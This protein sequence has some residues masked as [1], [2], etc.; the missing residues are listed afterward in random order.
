MN[1]PAYFEKTRQRSAERWIQ[2]EADKELA[3]PWHQLFRQV[4]SPRHVLSELLQNADDAGAKKASVSFDGAT[5]VFEHDGD[6]FNEEQF[7]SLCRFGFSNKRSLHTIGFRGIGF[8]STF[9]LGDRVEVL[10]PSL[11]VYFQKKR[12]TEP[13]W[14]EGAQPRD[15]TVVRVEVTDKNRAHQ[16]RANLTEW[17]ESPSSLLFFRCLKELTIDGATVR[18]RVTKSGPVPK[19]R[20]LTLTGEETQRLLLLQSAA[21]ALPPEAVEELRAERDVE[22]LHLP[23]CEVEVVLGLDQPQR[24]YVVLPTGAE[25]PLPFSI[26]APFIQDPARM[27]IKEPSTSPTNRWLLERAGRLVG[28]TML[29]WLNNRSLTLDERAVAYEFLSDTA[30]FD[31]TK[32][33]GE[34]AEAIF[35]SFNAVIAEHPIVLTTAGKVVGS[36]EAVA[37]PAKLHEVWEP[38]PL[39]EI[40]G[41]EGHRHVAANEISATSLRAMH[42]RE[43]INAL[44][45]STVI[46]RL[47]KAPG[48]V[49]PRSWANLQTL[50]EFVSSQCPYEWQN[51]TLRDLNIVPT[52]GDRVLHAAK[53]VIRLSSKREQLSDDDWNFL[54]A[55]SSVVLPDWI[56]WLSKLAPKRLEG[57]APGKQPDAVRLLQRLGLH[58][59][60]PVDRLV[61]NASLRLID[62]G[63]P[64]V[65]DCVRM[66]QIIAA[67]SAHVPDGFKFVTRD[68]HLRPVKYGIVDDNRGVV[69]AL[70]P[71]SWG[72]THL[73]H[74]DYTEQFVSCKQQQWTEWASSSSSGL[75][76]FV[77]VQEIK[78]RLWSRSA[79]ERVAMERGGQKPTRYR[80][81]R[82]SFVL[83]DHGFEKALM[84]NWGEE[85]KTDPGLW[86]R[87]MEAVLRAPPHAWKD[88]TSAVIHQ[89]GNRY[90]E[91]L[92]C[93]AVCAAWI[94]RFRSLACIPDNFGKLHV[95]AEL[96]ILTPDTAP[97]IGIEGFV[98]PELDTPANR[99]LLRLLGVRENAADAGK[100][101]NRI[102]ALAQARDPSRIVTEI[103][104]LYEALDR[105][106]AR[107]APEPLREV[108]A[109]FAAEAIILADN[110]EWLS[111]G[112]ISIF[113]DT[114]V[115]AP[116]IHSSV[117]RLA[118]WPRLDMPERPAV[119]KTVEW[120]RSLTAGRK[121]DPAELKRV[122]FALQR[123]PVRIWHACGHW[124]TLDNTWAEVGSLTLRLT[125]Q[126]LTKWSD[127]SPAIK[128]ATANFQMLSEETTRI[129]PFSNLRSLADSVEFRVT[130]R[131]G[132]GSESVPAWLEELSSGFCRLRIGSE[133][134]TQRIRTVGQRLRGSQWTR[135]SRIEVTPYVDG[136]PA[137]EPTTPK[138]FWSGAQIYAANVAIARL[139]KDLAD[140]ISRPFAHHG[141]ASAIGACLDRD[142]DFVREY[143]AS[144]F[145]LDPEA[146]EA[147]P[148]TPAVPS[149]GADSS[150]N[151]DSLSDQ[152]GPGESEDAPH[153]DE[154]ATENGETEEQPDPAAS[155]P[156]PSRRHGQNPQPTPSLFERYARQR[157]FHRDGHADLFTHR[158]GR[159]IGRDEQPFHWVEHAADGKL[160][161][162]L[163]VS[164]Q[165]LAHG[166]EVAHELWQSIKDDPDKT[167]IILPGDDH[168]VSA[169]SGTQLIHKK[170]A[171]IVTLYP[172]RYRLVMSEAIPAEGPTL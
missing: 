113:G 116:G 37:V 14:I 134:E 115:A 52:R 168:A 89:E 6:D 57:G 34:C 11:A 74:A 127:L 9:S 25:L 123:D 38:G 165:N 69:E 133:E 155:G 167:A 64:N 45:A 145:T 72:D 29:A 95:P 81:A 46:S 147:A 141:I 117:Q 154:T 40:F 170:N 114:E 15:A 163:W 16:L 5:F 85:A 171:G 50:W 108:A 22:D 126:E 157:G 153:E 53:Q 109:T 159:W 135:F 82:N 47:G 67:L 166:V 91:A 150:T 107:L 139:H 33:G 39:R 18:K 132:G 48:P 160:R 98:H 101:I 21:E 56:A 87:I 59:P 93:G 105:V 28:E 86:G 58:E 156:G 27:K 43:W 130:H 104:R 172:A 120:L 102:R 20:Y 70:V 146:P 30:T 140:E 76:P 144:A 112:E 63:E 122:R 65:S 103:A 54:T 24:L 73:L 128:N 49:R 90:T 17:T 1:P 99:P 119:E 136:D 94:Y 35:S 44:D 162:R 96:L 10:S 12:F 51:E 77:P 32:L 66:A 31:D 111:T 97:L 106:V 7:A 79:V 42:N 60:A 121:L 2:L 19:S 125:M 124:L 161:L 92:D 118:M 36:G 151:G 61:A 4:Q 62:S 88:K 78:E 41:Q 148:P 55:N 3:G 84:E 83:H 143:L 23:P 80:Y 158:D 100:I 26:N 164:E 129:E 137:G 138:A 13:V 142:R 149:V 110:H 75:E 8:K 169:L 68:F 131:D 71:A 152:A